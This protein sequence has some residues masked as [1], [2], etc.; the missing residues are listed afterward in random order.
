MKKTNLKTPRIQTT[1]TY[2]NSKAHEL[3]ILE[4]IAVPSCAVTF[5]QPL[6]MSGH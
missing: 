6:Q 5:L 3:F 1:L 4:I 2:L